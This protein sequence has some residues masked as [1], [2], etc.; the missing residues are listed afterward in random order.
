MYKELEAELGVPREIEPPYTVAFS[1]GFQSPVDAQHLAAMSVDEIVTFLS[2]WKHPGDISGSSPEG[3]SRAFKGAVAMDPARFAAE[4]PKFQGLDP[5]YVR[6]L[7]MGLREAMK[8]TPVISW[9]PVLGL[10]AWAVAQRRS[11]DGRQVHHFEQDPHWGWTRREIASLV[12]ELLAR[13]RTDV[14]FELRV[15]LWSILVQLTEDEDPNPAEE[16]KSSLDAYTEAINS[17]RGEALETAI[18]YALWVTRNLKKTAKGRELI[19]QGFEP[20]PE[21]RDVL[22]KHLD[23]QRDASRAVRS[24]YGRWFPWIHL[25]DSTWAEHNAGLIFPADEEKLGY[26]EA[27]WVAFIRFTP[28]Y[29]VLLDVLRD[30]YALAI[31]RIGKYK[32]KHPGMMESIDQKLARHLVAF[33]LRGRLN[34]TDDGGLFAT[35]WSKAGSALRAGAVDSVARAFRADKGSIPP[36]VVARAVALWDHIK[37]LASAE[38]A[39]PSELAGF[40]SWF[41]SGRFEDKWALRELELVLNRSKKVED[42]HHVV[43]RLASLS[44]AHQE[45]TLRCL[46]LIATE[47]DVGWRMLAWDASVTQILQNALSSGIPTLVDEAK[48]L[49]NQLLSMGYQQYRSLLDSR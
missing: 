21:V 10:C 4:A 33:V 35:F 19:A 30:Q 12:A 49:V 27:S 6:G 17:V 2:S 32:K 41:S 20:L 24:V 8:S 46:A 40:G 45:A 36:E 1:F 34:P 3:L 25:L 16:G 11:I 39:E 29:D 44:A 22:E 5:T 23:D 38:N 9:T 7:L 43:E 37:G 18:K 42:I 13:D 31:E 48:A 15:F 14:G 47:G 28:P 26:W